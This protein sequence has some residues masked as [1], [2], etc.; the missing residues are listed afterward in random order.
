MFLCRDE[1]KFGRLGT[2]E[3]FVSAAKKIGRLSSAQTYDCLILLAIIVE[4]TIIMPPILGGKDLLE[5]S[6]TCGNGR[7][8]RI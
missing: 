2:M 8:N 5:R 1:Y 6:S 3:I 7:S 4:N